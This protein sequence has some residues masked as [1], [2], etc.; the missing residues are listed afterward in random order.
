[1][2]RASPPH[3]SSCG[4]ASGRRERCSP[5]LLGHQRSG[6]VFLIR[7]GGGVAVALSLTLE[8]DGCPVRSSRPG[9]GLRS[10]PTGGPAWSHRARASSSPSPGG[11]GWAVRADDSG[12]RNSS[13]FS[14][15]SSQGEE[16]PLHLASF[17]GT[18]GLTG[19]L[20]P[21]WEGKGYYSFAKLQMSALPEWLCILWK[22]KIP[23]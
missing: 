13:A 19:A 17:W 18:R 11:P 23:T 4:R 20:S 12:S 5:T 2:S 16:T 9:R 10:D 22:L 6:S 15:K 7:G 3:S 1:M 14:C 21:D 8:N